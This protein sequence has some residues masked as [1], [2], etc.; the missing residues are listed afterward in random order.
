MKRRDFLAAA[1]AAGLARGGLVPGAGAAEAA[2]IRKATIFGMLPK[3]LSLVDRF[4]LS[5]S[6]G[7]E[8]VEAYTMTDDAEVEATRKAAEESGLIVHSIMNQAHWS[9]PL[10]DPDP[11]V[12]KKSLEGLKTSIRNAKALKAETVLLVPGVV[13]PNARYEECFDR[14]Q[15][16]IKSVL[17]MAEDSNVIIAVENVWNKWLLSPV[18]FVSFVDSFKSPYV[19]AYLDLGNIVEYGYPEQ[20]VRSLGKRIKK[21]HVK[22]YHA[23]KR[24]WTDLLTGTIDW[25]AVIEALHEVGYTGYMT[26]ELKGGDKEYLA[27]VSRDMDKIIAGTTGT[28]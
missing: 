18:E 22:G 8:G 12:V 14:S 20:W 4:K 24:A 23:G 10:T 1:A 19:Q 9:F 2:R 27:A 5:K 28:A 11:E 26:A 7:F 6:V 3:E 21:L 25:K 17:P 15:K 16:A 13:K